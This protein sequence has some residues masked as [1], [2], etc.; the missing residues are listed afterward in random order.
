VN[1]GGGGGGAEGKLNQPAA[2]SHRG[3]SLEGAVCA[4]DTAAQRAV[5]FHQD[6]SA[7]QALWASLAQ[8]ADPLVKW[9]SCSGARCPPHAYRSSL[10]ADV[11][12]WVE[13]GH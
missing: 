13:S 10:A 12:Q 4:A 8:V 3:T 2:T 11:G 6:R 5:A 1:G 9:E 7:L